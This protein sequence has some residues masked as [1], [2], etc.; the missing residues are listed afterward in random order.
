MSKGYERSGD[1]TRIRSRSRLDN[2]SQPVTPTASSIT[3][4]NDRVQSLISLCLVVFVRA[5]PKL[6]AILA[7]GSR[8]LDYRDNSVLVDLPNNFKI[9]IGYQHVVTMS[10]AR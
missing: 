6:K 2:L 10:F 4:S 5:K 1:L 9:T 3:V 8:R 7:T